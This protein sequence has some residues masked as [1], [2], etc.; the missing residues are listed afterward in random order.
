[1]EDIPR[2]RAVDELHMGEKHLTMHAFV[3]KILLSIYFS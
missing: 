3:A 1:M 2:E